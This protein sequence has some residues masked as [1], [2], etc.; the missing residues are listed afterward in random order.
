MVVFFDPPIFAHVGSV[1]GPIFRI[2]FNFPV[3]VNTAVVKLLDE[4]QNDRWLLSSDLMR[5]K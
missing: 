4:V 3:L 2:N 5:K 1:V